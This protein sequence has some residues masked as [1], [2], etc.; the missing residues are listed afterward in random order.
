[1]LVMVYLG[2]I[3]KLVRLSRFRNVATVYGLRDIGTENRRMCPCNNNEA[4]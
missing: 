2:A 3:G 1:M 4:Q